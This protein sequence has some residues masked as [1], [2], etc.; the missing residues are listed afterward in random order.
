MGMSYPIR[1]PVEPVGDVFLKHEARKGGPLDPY[2][3]F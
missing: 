1:Q 3:G 2:Q